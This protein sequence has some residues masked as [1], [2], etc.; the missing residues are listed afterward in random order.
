MRSMAFDPLD[1]HTVGDKVPECQ[2]DLSQIYYST[3]PHNSV[4]DT[5]W[6]QSYYGGRPY[7]RHPD[8]SHTVVC[9]IR[10]MCIF[11]LNYR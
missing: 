1:Q 9:C 4:S 5:Y 10:W 6:Y 7:A 8:Q 2:R 11:R 3:L